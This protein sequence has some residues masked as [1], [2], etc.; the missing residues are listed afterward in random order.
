MSSCEGRLVPK[1]T[2]SQ[3]AA[4]TGRPPETLRHW[5]NLLDEM[6]RPV[7][8]AS[9]ARRYTEADVGTILE[10]IQLKN[11]GYSN[12]GAKQ[13]MARRRS[14]RD[15]IENVEQALSVIQRATQAIARET[16]QLDNAREFL[17]RHAGNI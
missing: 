6:M 15:S 12:V 16:A 8:L 17:Q 10:L 2:I 11:E 4:L 14:K 5:E 13:E 3:V 7:R 1:Y 9:G